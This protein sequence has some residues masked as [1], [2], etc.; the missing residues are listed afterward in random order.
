MFS[1]DRSFYSLYLH[2]EETQFNGTV[3]LN[4]THKVQMGVTDVKEYGLALART[5]KFPSKVLPKAEFILKRIKD[6]RVQNLIGGSNGSITN[7]SSQEFTKEKLFYDLYATVATMCR[8]NLSIS[9]S[10]GVS[11]EL[12]AL[13]ES[14][15]TKCSVDL[16][17][18]IQ[19]SDLK[20]TF[21][22][23]NLF[24]KSRGTIEEETIS[25][26]ISFDTQ[27]MTN[28]DFVPETPSSNVSQDSLA[29][30]SS[31][32][33]GVDIL[34][35]TMEERETYSVH[36][37]HSLIKRMKERSQPVNPPDFAKRTDFY[38][39]AGRREKSPDMFENQNILE[40][41]NDESLD[42]GTEAL[43]AGGDNELILSQSFDTSSNSVNNKSFFGTTAEQNNSW[44]MWS[45]TPLDIK[46]E[47][48]WEN[49]V[50]IFEGCASQGPNQMEVFSLKTTPTDEELLE[51]KDFFDTTELA[52]SQFIDCDSPS[53]QAIPD[54]GLPELSQKRVAGDN[55]SFS[56]QS[57]NS[58]Y[59][60]RLGLLELSKRDK[61]QEC[62]MRPNAMPT[63]EETKRDF[64]TKYGNAIANNYQRKPT[65]RGDQF[66]TRIHPIGGR[67]FKSKTDTH[68]FKKPH[69]KLIQRSQAT[70]NQLNNTFSSVISSIPPPEPQYKN[71]HYYEWLGQY[72]R[73]RVKRLGIPNTSTRRQSNINSIRQSKTKLDIASVNRKWE[74]FYTD[75]RDIS[76]SDRSNSP[77]NKRV[78]FHIND[79]N[80]Q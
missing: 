67:S 68:L 12:K 57:S 5:V 14:F 44:K 9:S 31:F 76:G 2:V 43:T 35:S 70:T 77:L 56:S 33:S 49:S 8:K 21:S 20:T 6:R 7:R 1:I 54:S 27:P 29:T 22:E 65:N 34:E 38:A 66:S 17:H 55:E 30:K 79:Y 78:S 28:D 60:F 23:S 51:E 80:E 25:H 72:C 19:N 58:N 69:L 47:P 39:P 50:N 26:N 75:C 45:Q 37:Y 48:F 71:D 73:S 63:P 18:T 15:R 52:K 59:N 16:V 13:M 24:R 74:S 46:E 64:L 3:K 53:K 41:N 11:T 32:M 42:I 4:Y 36:S 62:N 10:G 40:D 61:S